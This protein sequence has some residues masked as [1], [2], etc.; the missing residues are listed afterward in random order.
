MMGFFMPST[1]PALPEAV[2]LASRTI[3]ASA[4]VY[5]RLQSLLQSPLACV[6]DVADLVKVDA[7]LA[8]AVLR[9]AN[10][11]YFHQGEPLASVNDA[12][13]RV[14][15]REV[16]R[17]V[18]VAVAGELFVSALPLY[19]LP[20]HLLWENSLATA[21]AMSLLAHAAGDDER[22]AYTLGLMRSAGRLVLQR[23]ALASTASIPPCPEA[24]P[25]FD[26]ARWETA[27][28]GVTHAE[29]TA[30]LLETWRF[31]PALAAA[32]RHHRHPENAPGDGSLAARLHLAC[33]I[34]DTLGKGLPGEASVWR[35]NADL[36]ARA[37]L[38]PGA[39][40]ECM[41]DT[42]AE[43]NRLGALVRGNSAASAA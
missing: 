22:P 4:R 23:V 20:G 24:S 14:G 35:E 32:V 13:N 40:Q 12:I 8:S 10:S 2:R 27:A 11:A 15:L 1:A 38:P 21:V 39:P 34:A 29:V 7:G 33:W 31:A 3:P 5:S 18:G 17:I 37:G 42:R 26:E 36:V 6:G 28:F 43:L 25:A 41:I 30:H 16:H 9:A 19:R